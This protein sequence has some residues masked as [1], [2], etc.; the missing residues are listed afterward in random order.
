[1][2]DYAAKTRFDRMKKRAKG[3]E[4]N[5]EMVGRCLGRMITHNKKLQ[6]LDLDDTGLSHK[7]IVD[8]IPAFSKAKSLLSFH[9]GKNP[10]FDRKMM[11]LFM[12]KLKLKNTVKTHLDLKIQ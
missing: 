1:M 4:S 10:G 12:R 8:L 3:K 6:Y 2:K 11:T 5:A 7:I 9:C